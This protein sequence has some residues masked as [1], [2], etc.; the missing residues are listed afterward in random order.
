MDSHYAYPAAAR[1]P[2][3]GAA[4]CTLQTGQLRV[5]PSAAHLFAI[6]RGDAPSTN[7]H[8]AAG[9]QRGFMERD[10][11][12]QAA[13]LMQQAL[14]R[15]YADLQELLVGAPQLYARLAAAWRRRHPL[16]AAAG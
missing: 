16:P 3:K 10:I 11:S 14:L 15:G 1:T 5:G 2:G 8:A 12:A 7:P 4:M 13:W 6:A 9:D